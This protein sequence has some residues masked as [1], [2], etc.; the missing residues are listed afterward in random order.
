M[1]SLYVICA[2]LLGFTAFAN[3]D[4]QLRA[5][6]LLIELRTLP[7]GFELAVSADQMAAGWGGLRWDLAERPL[8]AGRQGANNRA[9]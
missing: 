6:N 1:R 7:D 5:G 3:A 4:E 9:A 2:L 8:P